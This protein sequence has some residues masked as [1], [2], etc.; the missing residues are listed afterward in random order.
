MIRNFRSEWTVPIKP[1]NTVTP[2][3]KTP[4]L[5]CANMEDVQRFEMGT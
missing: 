1:D 5:W 4:D 2:L 3:S